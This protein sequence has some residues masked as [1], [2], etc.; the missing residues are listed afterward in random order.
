M[1][2]QDAVFEKV[3]IRGAKYLRIQAYDN[4]SNASD[5]I[6]Y[7]DPMIITENYQEEKIEVKRVEEYDKENKN[8]SNKTLSRADSKCVSLTISSSSAENTIK[9][10]S[11][12]LADLTN[13]SRKDSLFLKILSVQR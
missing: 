12:K 10:K 11:N 5:H 13:V 2:K 9:P 3:D 4:G 6:V 8:Y 1:P 7:V